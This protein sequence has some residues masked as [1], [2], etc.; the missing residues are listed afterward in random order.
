MI[1]LQALPALPGWALDKINMFEKII[2]FFQWFVPVSVQLFLGIMAYRLTKALGAERNITQKNEL[3][4][5]LYEKR[6]K[7]FDNLYDFLLELKVKS[8]KF[9]HQIIS[10]TIAKA[11]LAMNEAK[12]LFDQE[13]VEYIDS[14]VINGINYL[15][16]FNEGES[17]NRI[18]LDEFEKWNSQCLKELPERLLK[19]LNFKNINI[20]YQ[21][22]NTKT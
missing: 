6:Y 20:N 21:H 22:T 7:I 12:F 14:I 4:L 15:K 3:K 18:T 11:R 8:L 1:F 10:D 19:Y 16:V 17:G 9:D 13:L 5:K 2:S